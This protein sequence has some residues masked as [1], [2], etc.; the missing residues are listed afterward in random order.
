[1][2]DSGLEIFVIETVL[3]A[4]N[5]VYIPFSLVLRWTMPH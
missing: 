4:G 5:A 1:M 2:Q 3:C